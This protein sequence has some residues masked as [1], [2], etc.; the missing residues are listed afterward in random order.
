MRTIYDLWDV[1]TGNLIGSYDDE[2]PALA[3]VRA[4]VDANGPEYADVL[5]LGLEDETGFTQHL[6]TG[7]ELLARA[8]VA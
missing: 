6:G 7:T 8:R 4:L 2:E 5:E 1:D 3:M